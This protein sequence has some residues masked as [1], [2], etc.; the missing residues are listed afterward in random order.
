MSVNPLM[1]VRVDTPEI[2]RAAILVDAHLGVGERPGHEGAAPFGEG[3]VGSEDGVEEFAW[4]QGPAFLDVGHGDADVFDGGRWGEDP[5]DGEF[6]SAGER[7]DLVR[8]EFA[9]ATTVY[10]S[11][12]GGEAGV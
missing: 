12:E 5:A 6:E 3:L 2:L 10:G 1:H 11:F 9:D 7:E 8:G 4:V